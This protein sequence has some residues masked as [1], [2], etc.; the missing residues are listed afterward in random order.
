MNYKLN[1]FR[2]IRYSITKEL[3][4]TILA[5]IVV[6][7]VAYFNSKVT[8]HLPDV[9]IDKMS[10]QVEKIEYSKAPY[11]LFW[12]DFNNEN[13]N[14]NV[15]MLCD[16]DQVKLYALTNEEKISAIPVSKSAMALK[17]TYSG[18]LAAVL[19][20][21]YADLNNDG[22]KEKIN[23]YSKADTIYTQGWVPVRTNFSDSQIPMEIHKI[24][25]DTVEVLYNQKPLENKEVKLYSNR[26]LNKSLKTDAAGTLKIKDVRDLREGII[27]VY[28]EENNVYNIASY[29][30]ESNK[31]FTKYHYKA[32]I[33]LAKVLVISVVVIL[34]IS[35]LR[36][37]ISSNASKKQKGSYKV[38]M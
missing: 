8:F 19:P 16:S 18:S 7:L 1:I 26:G 35:A 38:E 31:L 32:L 14:L 12:F 2:I 36:R 37:M 34:L 17:A 6:F 27:V 5:M 22:T 4:I 29:T 25:Y 3:F 23:L 30:V 11:G 24:G 33:P 9:T 20:S 13:I 15:N 21:F 28:Q 10:V